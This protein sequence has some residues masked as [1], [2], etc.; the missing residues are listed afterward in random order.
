MRRYFKR[1]LRC[2]RLEMGLWAPVATLIVYRDS[3]PW[4]DRRL[5]DVT[6]SLH[7]WN[8]LREWDV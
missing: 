3:G 5:A 2:Y 1:M 8:T 4:Y 7:S 6:N